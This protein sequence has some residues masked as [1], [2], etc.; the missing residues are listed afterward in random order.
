MVS[1]AGIYYPSRVYTEALAYLLFDI[2]GGVWFPPM[3]DSLQKNILI[4][5]VV[6]AV[7]GRMTVNTGHFW[8]RRL[9]FIGLFI[10][11]RSRAMT[12]FAADIF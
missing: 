9:D 5:R 10:V 12:V 8:L 3:L 6:A 2:A 7:L 11:L 1:L 4:A